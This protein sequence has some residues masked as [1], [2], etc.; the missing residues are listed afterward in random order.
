MQRA[1]SLIRERIITLELAP[2]SPIDPPRLAE[3]LGM[4]PAPVQ[5]ALQ[6]LA[7]DGLVQ[8][9]PQ[10]GV[11]VSNVHLADLEQLSKMRLLLEPYSARLA[12]QNA[13]AEDLVVLK[14][15]RQEYT[16]TPP[17]DNRRL[18]DLDHKFHQAIAQAAGNKYL[19]HTLDRL[20]VLSQRLWFLALPDLD[21]LP[22]S[23]E[24]HVRL[25][26]AI[27]AQDADR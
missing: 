23:V 22:A 24:D 8:I 17:Q 26:E 7:H 6:L 19:A 11:H 20:F 12:A 27:E 15:L 21:L 9:D 1:Y 5:E 4:A 25:V 10:Y 16:E 14:S 3:D 13:T 2:G 18:L